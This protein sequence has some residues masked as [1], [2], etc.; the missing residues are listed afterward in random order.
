M[1]LEFA[2]TMRVTDK[3]DVYSFEVRALEVM[4]GR[5]PGD[6][7]ESQLSESS[8]SMNENA[9]LLLKDLLDQRLDPPTNALVE[10]VLLVMSLSLVWCIHILGLDRQCF[11]S[12]KNY[13]L[14]PCLPFSNHL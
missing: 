3:C 8:T 12:H 9:E 6:I 4:M 1:S 14:K 10:V 11:L 2:F 5:H 7:L 13:M